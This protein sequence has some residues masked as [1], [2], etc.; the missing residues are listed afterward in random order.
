MSALAV[1]LA[2]S[3]GS[4]AAGA[5][6]P[7][8]LAVLPIEV[9]RGAIDAAGAQAL[10]Q[11]LRAAAQQLGLGA[12]SV[13]GDGDPRTAA[14]AA[15]ATHYLL[16]SAASVE[17]A[18]VLLLRLFRADTGAQLSG[19]RAAGI[20]A[21][22]IRAD[23]QEKLRG[24]LRTELALGAPPAGL[25]RAPPLK[26]AAPGPAAGPNAAA[27]P[28]AP[29]AQDAAPS[30]SEQADGTLSTPLITT[31][32]EV[33]ADVEAVRG[34]HR[35]STLRVEVLDDAEFAKTLR[36]K[37]RL[38]LTP[39]V[40]DEERARWLAFGL[41]PASADPA[42]ILLGVLDEQAAG[43]YDPR[44][45]AL[46]VRKNLPAPLLS[47]GPEALRLVL[48]HEIEHALQ[49]QNFG[50]VQLATLPDQD[51]RLARSALYEGDA[52]ATMIA[53]A[54]RR[55]G[56]KIKPAIAAAAEALRAQ[57]S[58]SFLQQSG[59]S[60]A[61]LAAPEIVREELLVPY[62][63]G[64][65][66][67]AEVYARGGFPLVDKMFAHPPSSSHQVLHP[68]AY[69]QGEMPDGVPMPAVPPGTRL[70]SRGRMGELASRIALSQCVDKAVVA[71]L[72]DRWAGDSYVIAQGPGKALALVWRS[73]WRGDAPGPVANLLQMESPCWEERAS[74]AAAN[75]W[76]M[77]SAHRIR[78][79][80]AKVVL[81]RGLPEA[82]LSAVLSA[83]LAFE[84][85]RQPQLAPLGS[86][87]LPLSRARATL[88]SGHFR[89]G[90]LGLEGVVPAGFEALVAGPDLASDALGPPEPNRELLL[91]IA[92]GEAPGLL[93]LSL[94]STLGDQGSEAFFQAAARGFSSA[95][96]AGTLSLVG[97]RQIEIAG[98]KASERTWDLEEKPW[99]LR[100]ALLPVCGG[101]ASLSIVRLSTNQTK[102]PIDHFVESLE[103]KGAGAVCEDLE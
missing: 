9:R 7:R 68:D 100:I 58:E 8:F 10:E 52:M 47:S 72:A 24:L 94:V 28:G 56:R 67:V 19:T 66:L 18:T 13:A 74:D 46:T 78:T 54:A 22:A 98:E 15:G 33:T 93:S 63:A 34:L 95:A 43:F 69:L 76:T 21:A 39:A 45:H 3:L 88:E 31:I 42:K 23:A 79:E 5:A 30:P 64:L 70:V 81:V 6:E 73:A 96:H 17:G 14:Q 51:T 62:S 37:A 61:L 83:G 103:R 38:E 89:S 80:G 40:I 101:K 16:V 85:S 77:T 44:T 35:K 48:A 99:R 25:E 91:K 32:R 41:A 59:L 12:V 75:G 20:G 92:H 55:A 29:A 97:T 11:E 82:Q 2:L 49:D 1:A 87:A 84:L 57:S 50:L 65:G 4:L 26:P 71:E 60:P 86:L 27:S 53:Y 102:A 36:E 90:R